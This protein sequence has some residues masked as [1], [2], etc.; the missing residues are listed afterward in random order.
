MEPA[1]ATAPWLPPGGSCHDEI[2]ALRNRYFVVTDEGW[3]QVGFRM[4][5]DE[6]HSSRFPPYQRTAVEILSV[7]HPSS[8]FFA[9]RFRSAACQKIQL[10]PGGSQELRRFWRVPFIKP[11]YCVSCG[12]PS[13]RPLQRL[14]KMG[15]AYH[16][17]YYT[18]SVSLFGLTA[19]SE[20][21]P[22]RL[23][24]KRSLP[25]G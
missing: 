24:R 16:L 19:P 14:Y 10:P 6:R 17:M 3:R 22:R 11:L 8:V 5:P 20:R 15:N 1:P 13:W 2:S 23:R 12:S 18:P 25:Y 4:H 9:N 7:R 21:E